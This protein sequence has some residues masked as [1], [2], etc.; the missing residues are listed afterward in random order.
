MNRAQLEAYQQA[1]AEALYELHDGNE[2]HARL[3]ADPRCEP[4]RDYVATMEPRFLDVSAMLAKRWS[5]K[6]G[7]SW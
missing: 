1:L 4:F 6:D 5:L 3:L 7:E 2:I